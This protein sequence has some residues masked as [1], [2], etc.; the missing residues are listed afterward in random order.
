MLPPMLQKGD[1]IGIVT[2]GSS[3]KPSH[4]QR[5]LTLLTTKGYQILLGKNV[6]ANDFPASSPQQRAA[7]LMGMFTNSNVSMII[8][9]RG[10]TGVADILPY[11][12]YTIIQQNPKILV[13]YSDLSILLNVIN[14]FTGLITYNA[15]MTHD[16]D[17]DAPSFNLEQFFTAITTPVVPRLI[18]NPP[19][20]PL[21]SKVLGKAVGPIVGGNLTSIVG[22]LGTPFEIDT[23]GKILF[24]EDINENSTRIY[25][26]LTHLLRAGKLHDAS[27][28]IMGECTKCQAEYNTTY[29][30]IIEKLLIP[31]DRPLLTNL[32]TGHG[33][34]K[35]TIP[36]G[37]MVSLNTEDRTIKI[38]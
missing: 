5:G 28:I 16:F 8:G 29:E 32:A 37:A 24:L 23:R 20:M 17:P 14:H 30:Q 33:E 4:I 31:L 27:G 15:P 2:L 12:D 1:T 38:L 18:S 7:E 3:V 36:I 11:L 21:I 19:H 26:F 35:V 10:G 25:R 9:S 22:S 13:G 6:Y 34:Y